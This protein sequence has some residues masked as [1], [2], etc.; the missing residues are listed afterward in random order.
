MARLALLV[1]SPPHRARRRFTYPPRSQS[2]HIPT[3]LT[4][5]SPRSSDTAL[6]S[7]ATSSCLA[8]R[9]RPRLHPAP[10]EELSRGL[11]RCPRGSPG[12]GG[13][14]VAS[15]GGTRAPPPHSSSASARDPIHAPASSSASSGGICR[16]GQ[17]EG[18]VLLGRDLERRRRICF[19]LRRIGLLHRIGF[20]R[21]RMFL[22]HHC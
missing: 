14:C 1:V 13:S 10:E 21:W 19:L 7:A 17:G 16:N 9:R 20:H 5:A 4:V 11:M 22:S 2:L 8:K 6:W 18:P 12:G 15:D 3:A